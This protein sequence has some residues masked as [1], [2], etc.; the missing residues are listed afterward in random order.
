M[1][2]EEEFTELV[3]WVSLVDSKVKKIMGKGDVNLFSNVTYL[4]IVGSLLRLLDAKVLSKQLQ[5]AGL[6]I[7]RKIIEMENKDLVTPSADW[8]TE[9]WV[10][11]RGIIRMKQD[12]MVE[13]GAIQ[14]LCKHISEVEDAE[15]QEECLLV[16]IS[17][18]LGGNTKAQETFYA[19][20]CN[21]DAQENKFML[22]IK[23]ILM[24]NFE[25]TKKFMIEK[26][27]K[28]EMVHKM[29]MRSKDE[30]KKTHADSKENKGGKKKWNPFSKS[31]KS[32]VATEEEANQGG[33]SLLMEGNQKYE[34]GGEDGAEEPDNDED[35]NLLAVEVDDDVDQE[36]HEEKVEKPI[37]VEQL[38]EATKKRYLTMVIRILRF[39]QLLCEGHYSDLQNNLREQVNSQGTKSS[40]SFD[41]VAYVSSMFTIYVKS[42]VNCYSTNLGNQIIESLIEFIQGPCRESQRTLVET[43][44][45]DCCRDLLNQGMGNVDELEIKGFGGKRKALLNDIK[46]NSVKLLLSILEGPVDPEISAR[47]SAS[48]GDFQVVIRRMESVYFQFLEDELNLPAEAPANKVQKSLQ[49]DS[50]DS[51]I[52]E[53]FDIFSLLN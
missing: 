20:M 4:N 33:S 47:I 35:D 51:C 8:N 53:G 36:E 15:I 9:D 24:R 44:A 37:S 30:K 29:K 19:F 40:R 14:F 50:F 42:Y 38:E 6:S 10:N 13:R 45:I 23:S 22:T 16:C 48:L 25:L 18:V 46:M 39:L 7:L 21:E 12:S 5:I 52:L 32:K 1:M 28:L 49:K 31:K 11:Y 26:N 17:L 34:K 3:Q 27:A 43:K 2:K 41:F